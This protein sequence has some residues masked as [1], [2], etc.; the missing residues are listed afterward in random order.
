[1]HLIVSIVCGDIGLRNYGNNEN[2][3]WPVYSDCEFVRIRSTMVATQ[4]DSDIIMIEDDP[5]SGTAQIDAILSSNFT[6]AFKSDKKHS[7]KGFDLN[8]SCLK[9]GEWT[10]VGSGTC[11]K[12]KRPH[13]DYHGTDANMYTKYGNINQTCSKF[14]ISITSCFSFSNDFADGSI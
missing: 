4:K 13:P 6:V 3:I 2:K 14:L 5:Y 1:M 12:V 11:K 10:P 7:D 9:W 8:W